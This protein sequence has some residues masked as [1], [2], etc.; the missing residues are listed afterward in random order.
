M[1][2][3]L[4]PDICHNHRN[5]WLCKIFQ[6]SVKFYEEKIVLNIQHVQ[7]Y[8]KKNI[9]LLSVKILHSLQFTQSIILHT[10]CN[11]TYICSQLLVFNI[12][13]QIYALV[14][15]PGPRLWMCEQMTNI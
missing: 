4:A 3:V 1:A 7:S 13:S 9:I 11:F 15:I 5:R 14:K 12:L 2:A 8:N 10:Q 6:S